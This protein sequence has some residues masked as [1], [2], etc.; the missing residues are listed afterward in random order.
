VA[1]RLIWIS[2]WHLPGRLALTAV[3]VLAHGGVA[4]RRVRMT[5]AFAVVSVAMLA[6]ALAPPLG[7]AA[8]AQVGGDFAPILLPCSIAFPVMLYS[9][10]AYGR[11]REP[12]LVLVVAVIGAMITASRLWDP[13]NWTTGVPTGNGWRLFILAALPFNSRRK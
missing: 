6:L 13:G 2:D 1:L 4:L 9:V 11:G 12:L 8:A 10:A 7:G 5:A 3:V